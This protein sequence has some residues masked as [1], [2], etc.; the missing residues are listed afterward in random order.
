MREELKAENNLKNNA[1][2]KND[3]VFC[4]LFNELAKKWPVK[5]RNFCYYIQERASGGDQP[6]RGENLRLFLLFIFRFR[7]Q[8]RMLGGRSATQNGR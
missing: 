1:C 3:P 7:P 5:S 4:K 2:R 6:M 8:A